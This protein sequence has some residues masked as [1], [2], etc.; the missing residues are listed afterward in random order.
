ML[1][2]VIRSIESSPY[3]FS[4]LFVFAV[5]SHKKNPF[6]FRCIHETKGMGRLHFAKA[7]VTMTADGRFLRPR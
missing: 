7:S 1:Q 3:V 6:R 5:L 4:H 2:P